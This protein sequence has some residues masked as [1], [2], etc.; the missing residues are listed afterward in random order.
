MGMVLELKKTSSSICTDTWI[1]T[2]RAWKKKIHVR[3]EQLNLK[4]NLMPWVLQPWAGFAQVSVSR[5]RISL[6]RKK[7]LS[8]QGVANSARLWIQIRCF[9]SIF[10]IDVHRFTKTK[11]KNKTSERRWTCLKSSEII[12][13]S[14]V[15]KT[16]P[17]L[18]MTDLFIN[19]VSELGLGPKVG[20]PNIGESLGEHDIKHQFILCKQYVNNMLMIC[21]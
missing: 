10:M 8:F 4:R 12:N 20:W 6:S 19:G 2:T 11:P 15:R 14:G 16:S 21:W 5:P 9:N 13:I 18:G 1:I 7:A 17:H 3:H